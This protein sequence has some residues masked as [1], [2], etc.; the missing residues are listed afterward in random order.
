MT[1]A[2]ANELQEALRASLIKRQSF[3]QLV[4]LIIML[5]DEFDVYDQEASDE[6]KERLRKEGYKVKVAKPKEI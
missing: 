2:A 1:Q 6:L 3:K 4:E 5:H